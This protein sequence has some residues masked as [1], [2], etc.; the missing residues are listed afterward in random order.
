M[1]ISN[2]SNFNENNRTD[3]FMDI[4]K[5]CGSAYAKT[6]TNQSQPSSDLIITSRRSD[7]SVL[8]ACWG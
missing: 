7:N 1:S 2:F 8:L 5:K 3:S 4:V 6:F